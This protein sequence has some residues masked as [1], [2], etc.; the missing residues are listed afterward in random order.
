MHARRLAP[1]ARPRRR[2]PARR[3]TAGRATASCVAA[4][5]IGLLLVAGC[6][7]ARARGTA[8]ACG[9][10]RT[11]AGVPVHIHVLRGSVSCATA[12][13]VERDYSAQV[14]AGQVARDGGPVRVHGW[15]CQEF[16]TPVVLKTGK[17]SKCTEGSSEILAVL[18]PPT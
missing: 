8:T 16:A 1:G 10:A 17:A 9:T 12:M 5:A 3:A 18:P 4:A 7:G 2:R 6:S 14:R 15:T 11:A 13:K